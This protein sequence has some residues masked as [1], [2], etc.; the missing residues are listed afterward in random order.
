MDK[1][2][3][4]EPSGDCQSVLVQIALETKSDG[5]ESSARIFMPKSCGLLLKDSK[6]HFNHGFENIQTYFV[7]M[8]TALKALLVLRFSG[9]QL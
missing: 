1:Q 4:F 2:S 5:S 3:E 9:R 8:L 6:L 7:A